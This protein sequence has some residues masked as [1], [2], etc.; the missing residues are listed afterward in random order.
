MDYDID[1]A[2]MLSYSFSQGGHF[3]H[4]SPLAVVNQNYEQFKESLY[5]PLPSGN[6][7]QIGT[8]TSN[9]ELNQLLEKYT[10]A[11]NLIEKGNIIRE[12]N[13]LPVPLLV[14]SK[15]SKVIKE[16]NRHNLYFQTL[17]KKGLDITD[18]VKNF[19]SFNMFDIIANPVNNI[20]AQS[21]IDQAVEAYKD[22]AKDTEKAKIRDR[23]QPG[24]IYNKGLEL[25][26]NMTGK[27]VIG[28]T[29][30]GMKAL[31]SI[32]HSTNHALNTL[33]PNEIIYVTFDTSINGITYTIAG[34]S[35]SQTVNKKHF[36]F[37]KR[38]LEINE[39]NLS[40]IE[41]AIEQEKINKEE[42]EFNDLA[43]SAIIEA[44]K[45]KN[46]EDILLVLSALLSL[47]TDNAKELILD[48]I[49]AGSELASLYIC[50]ITM[51]VSFTDLTDI[52]ISNSMN[53]IS[54]IMK[55]NLFNEQEGM[56]KFDSAIDYIER[57]PS[58][59]LNPIM[60]Y[61][62]AQETFINAVKKAFPQL[63]TNI[64]D[65]LNPPKK[66]DSSEEINPEDILLEEL[67]GDQFFESEFEQE[68]QKVGKNK[69]KGKYTTH[70]LRELFYSMNWNK[71]SFN[72]FIS[73][74]YKIE[75]TL[76]TSHLW[77]RLLE[78]LENWFD[79]KQTIDNDIVQLESIDIKRFNEAIKL[80]RHSTEM[81]TLSSYFKTNQGI[82][83]DPT[84]LIAIKLKFENMFNDLFSAKFSKNKKIKDIQL[85]EKIQ[86]SRKNED[87]TTTL[88]VKSISEIIEEI[89]K[90][91]P[92]GI[93][94]MD[95]FFNNTNYRNK[96]IY[97]YNLVKEFQNVP[98]IISTNSHYFGYL[99]TVNTLIKVFERISK[100]FNIVLNNSESILNGLSIFKADQKQRVLKS[101]TTYIDKKINNGWMQ[102]TLDTF[103]IPEGIDIVDSS[104]KPFTTTAPTAIVLGTPWGN[105]A[106]KLYMETKVIPDLKNGILR[107]GGKLNL[108]NKF[109][110]NLSPVTITDTY[111]NIET[112]YSIPVE[113]YP[114]TTEEELELHS[115]KE[116]LQKLNIT[117]NNGH[118]NHSILNLLFLYNMIVYN[119]GNSTNALTNLFS[120]L[121]LGHSFSL[122]ESYK[123]FVSEYDNSKVDMFIDMEELLAEA[124]PI[125]SRF[126]A[127]STQIKDVDD[128]LEYKLFKK[129]KEGQYQE[130]KPTIVNQ[131]VILNPN[132]SIVIQEGKI[133]S[134]NTNSGQ[135]TDLKVLLTEYNNT[136]SEDYQVK[137]INDLLVTFK[138]GEETL[139][140]VQLTNENINR[141]INNPC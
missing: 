74:C 83:T 45:S 105:K 31:L 22:R 21:S 63:E 3:V 115:Y 99:K 40:D 72:T 68:D 20:Q 73:E 120:D 67:M 50:G 27:A 111:G 89:K 11:K 19:I 51:G 59:L 1:C 6:E 2:S 34:N 139:I 85:S 135:I 10:N 15:Y 133:Q 118:Q 94:S 88:E 134:I 75:N 126:T 29:A 39:S 49:N 110:N 54:N 80:Y 109:I 57:G 98:Y 82:P 64:N 60:K 26:T 66:K 102:S 24:N 53:A 106:F 8:L 77:F 104:G 108:G 121:F 116:S 47:A 37:K 28:I 42:N 25:S 93:I 137:N 38:R 41:K 71:D 23:N 62:V 103:I 65:F 81:T 124:T 35:F 79:L 119:G 125:S 32:T 13:K 44:S 127:Q 123:N 86:V 7:I 12:I 92:H 112:A 52:L 43:A 136:V 113:V 18:S 78:D 129:D 30:A 107:P 90:V 17:K 122:F 36:D 33:N 95:Q 96:V 140:D 84:E 141:I 91:F 69:N 48:K 100:K 58:S 97:Y 76:P 128:S 87:G 56:S 55:G 16:I 130:Y 46:D 114:K 131:T 9:S 61:E 14:D 70:K 5:L 117:Y 132:L 101:I 138:Q 4:W